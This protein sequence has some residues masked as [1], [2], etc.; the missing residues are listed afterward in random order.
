ML[1]EREKGEGK[2]V[3]L[4]DQFAVWSLEVAFKSEKATS[5]K[6]DATRHKIARPVQ[7]VSSRSTA[8]FPEGCVDDPTS[9]H[10]LIFLLG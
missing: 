8:S 1:R 4:K 5:K 6:N 2:G 7:I 9:N 10:V 3:S